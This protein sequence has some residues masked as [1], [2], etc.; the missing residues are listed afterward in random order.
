MIGTGAA[1]DGGGTPCLKT[2][3]AAAFTPIRTASV[4]P[5][6]GGGGNSASL[7]VS[8]VAPRAGAARM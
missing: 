8:V 3:F 1:G 7:T 5:S 6:A 2:G 4:T